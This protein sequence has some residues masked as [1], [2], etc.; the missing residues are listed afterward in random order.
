MELRFVTPKFPAKYTTSM[1]KLLL[2]AGTIVS[3]QTYAQVTLFEDNFESGAG[4]WTLNGGSGQNQWQVNNE[5]VGFSG[6]IDD[7]PAQPGTFTGGT[8]SMY[9]HIT[10][11]SICTALDVCNANFDTGSASDQ[12]ATK[13]TNVSTT[14]YNNVT[15]DFYYLCAGGAGVSYGIVEYSV[16][17]G[18]TWTAASAQ[19]S[20]VVTW[21]QVSITNPAFNNQTN[22][23]FRFRWVN[24]AAGNDPAFSVDEVKLTGTQGS[25][26]TVAT[27]AIMNASHCTNASSS[28]TVPFMASGTVNAGNVYTA[29]LSDASGSFASPTALG[30]LT[31]SSTG[32]L[33]INGTIP[34]GLPA[35]TGYQ[36]R[37]DASDPGTTGAVSATS[38]S[39]IAPPA[40]SFI[41]LPA[42]GVI[43]AGESATIL[44]NGGNSYAWS[45]AGSLDNSNTATVSAT[46]TTTTTYSV[47]VTGQT[48]CSA[49]GTFLVTVDQCASIA[50]NNTISLSVFPN[51]A[52]SQLNI[53]VEGNSNP[54]GMT[55]TD[56]N[57]RVVRS[58]ETFTNQIDI[59]NLNPGTYFLSIAAING[60]SKTIFIK[61]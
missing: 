57:G 47:L 50:E 46:P 51:P 25:F 39:I 20:G 35:G 18:S 19:Y 45:P 14:G 21:T 38:I 1:K 17:N 22:F 10:N 5:Y 61:E 41:S 56:I 55:V 49:T 13:T 43:C 7:T 36:V 48:G 52:A 29:Q 31:S 60:I 40:V 3:M 53:A 24:G 32:S 42:D 30:T 11:N 8:Q 59:S 23:K 4:N 15:L 27:A 2:L 34:S 9:M 16:D 44:A 26:A 58:F 12:S 28:I 54:G 37:V 6:F 33:S